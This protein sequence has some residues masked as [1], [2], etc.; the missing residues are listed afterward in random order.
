MRHG[1][2]E[3]LCSRQ[4]DDEI[5]LG[6]LLDREVA[7]LRSAQNFIDIVASAPEQVRE[8]CT[9]GHQPSRFDELSVAGHCR[10]SRGER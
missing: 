4:I 7:G 8:V 2:T 9:I 10:Q 1:E 6:W 5:E 3:R